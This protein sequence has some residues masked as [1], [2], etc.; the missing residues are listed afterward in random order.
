MIQ[1]YSRRYSSVG[2]RQKVRRRGRGP[3]MGGADS[4]LLWKAVGVF[5]SFAAVVGVAASLWLGWQIESGLDEL[6]H[7]RELRQE[8]TLRNQ[9]LL[10]DRDD[11]RDRAQVELAAAGLGLY[12]PTSQQV[13]RP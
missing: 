6:G 2:G 13:R 4:G 3:T 9:N 7:V 10:A 12:P 5:V 8:A 1:D 11:L